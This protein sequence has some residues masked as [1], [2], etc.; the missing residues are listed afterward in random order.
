MGMRHWRTVRALRLE[1]TSDATMPC[2]N[3]K[4]LSVVTRSSFSPVV[5]GRA[6]LT[7]RF[8]SLVVSALWQSAL[9]WTGRNC[10]TPAANLVSKR[11]ELGSSRAT[12]LELLIVLLAIA[13]CSSDNSPLPNLSVQES[14]SV[15]IGSQSPCVYLFLSQI[16]IDPSVLPEQAES[17]RSIPAFLQRIA[18][19]HDRSLK[20]VPFQEYLDKA[21]AAG[22]VVLED[23]DGAISLVL[24]VVTVD[25]EQYLQM[26]GDRAASE[27]VPLPLLGRDPPVRVW[28]AERRATD[29]VNVVTGET[30]VAFEHLW[31]TFGVTAP[32]SEQEYRFKVTNL[33]STSVRLQVV[34][35]SC[36]CTVAHF[37]NGGL[38]PPSET[39]EVIATVQTG[40]K[41][42]YKQIITLRVADEINQRYLD[43]PLMLFGNQVSVMSVVPERLD[44]GA[45]RWDS[46]KVSRTVV[47]SGSSHDRFRVVDVSIDDLPITSSIGADG[48]ANYDADLDAGAEKTVISFTLDPSGLD[49]GTFESRARI[50]TTSLFRPVVELPIR[51]TIRPRVEA[52]PGVV[53]FGRAVS[54][55]TKEQS[56]SLV[57]AN[58]APFTAEV[59]SDSPDCQARVESKNDF[60][61][62]VIRA[63]FGTTGAFVRKVTL[64]VASESW[65]HKIELRCVAVVGAQ[66]VP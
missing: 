30:I 21:P 47:L 48:G 55:D 54:G 28:L 39:E 1:W 66:S 35:T 34:S 12:S 56:V 57:S 10:A 62:V 40:D 59:L 29:S 60:H 51:L 5:F 4:D 24:G 46:P 17:D 58:N 52:V 23:S 8:A 3:T 7:S 64:R 32:F 19:T 6:R 27:L 45:T 26:I 2:A 36:G 15:R 53:S 42:S 61:Q 37:A 20:S 41:T 22:A 50:T 13:G 14:R 11:G 9:C 25:G 18:E 65:S 43:F 49:P 38:I 44:F 63:E 31:H 16:G 33:G